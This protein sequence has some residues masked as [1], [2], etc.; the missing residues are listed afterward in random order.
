MALPP[1]RETC[2]LNC[3]M[4]ERVTHHM[5]ELQEVTG[6]MEEV[7]EVTRHMEEVLEGVQKVKLRELIV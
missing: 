3:G 1:L 4:P 2:T 7:L 5:E 6:H